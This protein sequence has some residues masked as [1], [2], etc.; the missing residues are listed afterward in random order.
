MSV[1]KIKVK[2]SKRNAKFLVNV[3]SHEEKLHQNSTTGSAGYMKVQPGQIAHFTIKSMEEIHYVSVQSTDGEQLC[4]LWA[5]NS[6]RLK[7]F[8][9]GSVDDYDSG[10]VIQRK[11]R[12]QKRRKQRSNS[13]DKEHSPV[14]QE[15]IAGEDYSMLMSSRSARKSKHKHTPERS[16]P[17]GGALPPSSLTAP[18][19]LFRSSSSPELAAPEWDEK[20]SQGK[21]ST[22]STY[23]ASTVTN[24]FSSELASD[25][26]EGPE[27]IYLG[28]QSKSTPL[29]RIV[30]A[31]GAGAFVDPF[32]TRRELPQKP[33]MRVAPAVYRGAHELDDEP[34]RSKSQRGRAVLDQMMSNMS[35]SRGSRLEIVEDRNMSSRRTKSERKS[36]RKKGN[37]KT[38]R[39]QRVPRVKVQAIDVGGKVL[40]VST[41]RNPTSLEALISPAGEAPDRY[42]GY[43][44]SQREA[45][46]NP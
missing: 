39:S 22:H 19:I 44:R 6:L 16:R 15:R 1:R 10:R 8:S 24:S 45:P 35:M 25:S 26:D 14:Y 41:S 38:S 27:V 28:Q 42:Y 12:E 18:K 17:A 23:S 46:T 5:T 43:S 40:A 34:R 36:R 11:M 21:S 4:S 37:P 31:P 7:I 29:R 20:S 3:I 2:N 30:S 33:V 13:F 32:Y 9:D